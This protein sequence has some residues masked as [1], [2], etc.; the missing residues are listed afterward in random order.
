MCY[1]ETQCKNKEYP[2]RAQTTR[3]V[4]FGP[5]FLT[6]NIQLLHGHN[7]HITMCIYCKT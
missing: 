6:T 4:S 3:L 5:D 1:K 7:W 2:P